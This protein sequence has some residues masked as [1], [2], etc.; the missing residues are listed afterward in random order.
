M[1]R[2][3]KNRKRMERRRLKAIPLF[4]SGIH[5][6]EVAR[7]LGV[8]RQAVSPWFKLW[9]EGSDLKGTKPTGRP[10]KLE[11]ESVEKLMGLIKQHPRITPRQLHDQIQKEFAI[12]YNSKHIYRVRRS[13]KAR[14]RAS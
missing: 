13:L 2:L 8:S 7:R 14:L 4:E 12:D 3:S 6:A 1:T 11:D 10:M 5:P 9:K